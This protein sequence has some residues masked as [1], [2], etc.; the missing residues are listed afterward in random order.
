ME[1]I[2]VVRFLVVIDVGVRLGTGP[3]EGA[4][5]QPHKGA[6]RVMVL[7][8]LVKFPWVVV[9]A[10]VLSVVGVRSCAQNDPNIGE[11]SLSETP[12]TMTSDVPPG[13]RHPGKIRF[14]KVERPEP[15]L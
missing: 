3:A 5:R 1:L 4:T 2:V 7:N 15:I 10:V 13:R 8:V 11:G 12:S 6:T 14:E 9:V